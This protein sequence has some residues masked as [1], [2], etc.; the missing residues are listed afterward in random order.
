VI[1]AIRDAGGNVIGFA[2]VT[3]D[4]T[5]KKQA[6]RALEQ[7][8]RALHQTQKLES[9]GQ[10]TGGIAHDFNNLLTAIINSLELLRKRISGDPRSLALL[11]NAIDGA[12]RGSLLTQRMLAFARR[13]ELKLESVDVAT[14]VSGMMGLL[15]RSIGPAVNIHAHFPAELPPVCC[16]VNQ[17]E[18]ALLNLAVNARDAM[19]EGGT[20][21]VTAREES[22]G[23]GRRIG[24]KPGRYVCLSIADNGEGMDAQTLARATEPFFTTKGV[25]KGTGLGLAMVHG[26]A[27]QSGGKLTLASRPGAGTTAEIW[28]PA[29]PAKA[30]ARQVSEN[31]ATDDRSASRRLVILAVDD[32]ELVLASTSATLDDLGHQ[33][34]EANNGMQALE[35]VAANASIDIVITDQAMPGMTGLQLAQAIKNLR[36]ELPIVLATGYAELPGGVPLDIHRLSKPYRR[37]ELVEAITAA[38]TQVPSQFRRD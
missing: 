21:S 35:L 7:A 15:K 22:L 1:D 4:I 16:D 23:E 12:E 3:R 32:D 17:L 34:I 27:E 6:Q 8:Q 36:P 25:G 38:S 20:I 19:P 37:K 9:I 28:L 2:K 10:L 11:Q 18:S 31:E 33:V 30:A 26:L 13:Q 29:L 14:L 5:E 24:I